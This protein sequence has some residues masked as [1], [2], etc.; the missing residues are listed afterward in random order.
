MIPINSIVPL[1]SPHPP[2]RLPFYLPDVV[3]QP[4]TAEMTYR[5]S[6]NGLIRRPRYNIFWGF[7]DRPIR[8]INRRAIFRRWK[9]IKKNPR[10]EINDGTLGPW[11]R[12]SVFVGVGAAA[13]S[14]SDLYKWGAFNYFFRADEISISRVW[15]LK[16]C[17]PLWMESRHRRYASVCREIQLRRPW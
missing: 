2:A 16:E 14:P 13:R 3:Y 8:N 7:F 17:L 11:V 15:T 4:N 10:L 6:S 1:A 5:L 12:V 9:L